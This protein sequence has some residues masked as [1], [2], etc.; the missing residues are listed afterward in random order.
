MEKALQELSA[1]EKAIL[2]EIEECGWGNENLDAN[3]MKINKVAWLQGMSPPTLDANN[4]AGIG[5]LYNRGEDS[6]YPNKTFLGWPISLRKYYWKMTTETVNKNGR[7]VPE[8]KFD[9]TIPYT[10]V[11]MT[12]HNNDT[13]EYIF[14]QDIYFLPILEDGT[15]DV[16]PIYMTFASSSLNAAKQI[17]NHFLKMRVAKLPN[18]HHPLQITTKIE[19]KD[20]NSYSVPVVT[21]VRDTVVTPDVK[22]SAYNWYKIFAETQQAK[23]EEYKAIAAQAQPEP[24]PTQSIVGSGNVQVGGT[25]G[26]KN[27]APPS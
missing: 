11:D 22:I 27:F 9:S 4:P 20:S 10:G 26:V 1:E 16:T 15:T 25:Q 6:I 12:R 18:C 23:V 13:T 3:D 14:K 21:V 8:L 7:M 19:T 2:A 24:A 17:N 5:D